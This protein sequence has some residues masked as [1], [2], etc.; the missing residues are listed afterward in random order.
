[1]KK[2]SFKII[3]IILSVLML[4]STPIFALDTTATELDAE[5]HSHG[6]FC[7]H[8]LNQ[9]FFV[10]EE[11]IYTIDADCPAGYHVGSSYWTSWSRE[12]QGSSFDFCSRVVDIQREICNTCKGTIRSETVVVSTVSHTWSTNGCKKTC[13]CGYDKTVHVNLQSVT[14]GGY[15]YLYCTV[16]GWNNNY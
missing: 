15:T 10:I 14:F 3:S 6:D 12:T 11:P 8:S 1:M 7:V 16:C 4:F 2:R 9:E 5:V 13:S